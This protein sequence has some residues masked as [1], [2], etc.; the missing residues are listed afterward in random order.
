MFKELDV[1][2]LK[3]DDVEVGVKTTY[4]GTIVDLLTPDV[5][6]VEFVDENGDTIEA[7][8]YKVYSAD[9]LTKE[10]KD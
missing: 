7:A 9:Q 1:V 10:V 4:L 2:R 3:V 5:F 8:L 6:T